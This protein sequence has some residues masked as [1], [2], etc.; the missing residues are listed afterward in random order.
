MHRMTLLADKPLTRRSWAAFLLC[1]L[2]I[3]SPARADEAAVP[4]GYP[5]SYAQTIAAARQE[6][7]VVVY[8]VLSTKAAQPLVRDFEALYPGIAVDYDGDGGSNEVTDRYTG[9]LAAGKPSA[10]VMW[11]SAMDLQMQ[12]VEAGHAAV[13]RSPEAAK[14]PAWAVYGDRAWGTTFEP[15]VFVYNKAALVEADVP[16]DH[17]AL[18]RLLRAQAARLRGKVTMFDIEK[19]GVGFMFAAQDLRQQPAATGELLAALGAAA[20]VPSPGTGEMLTGVASGRF[21]LGYNIMGAYAQAR[22]RK[23]LPGLGVVV[24]RDYTQILSRVMFISARAPHPNA[25][26]LWADYLLSPRGQKIIG[27]ALELYTVRADVDAAYSAGQLA[28]QLGAAARPIPLGAALT[29]ALQPARHDALVA[30]WKAA[31]AAGATP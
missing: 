7:R 28:A 1:L 2:A 18:A 19:S 29:E 17:A 16:R 14:L 15:V 27:D 23:D 21:L 22:S 20:V 31:I 11:S 4:A 25:A 9:E 12:L 26:R 3:G 10:D 13:Y 5:A 6:G 8:S 24:P 30:H